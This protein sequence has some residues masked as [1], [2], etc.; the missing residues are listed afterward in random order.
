[1]HAFVYATLT[2]FMF[3]TLR[4]ADVHKRPLRV[5]FISGGLCIL[6]GFFIELIQ[7][8]LPTRSFDLLDELANSIGC[9]ITLTLLTFARGVAKKQ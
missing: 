6:Y 9:T 4:A 5:S 1:M 3:K 8:A 2:F 7:L